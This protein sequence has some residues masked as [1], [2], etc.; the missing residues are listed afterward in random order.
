MENQRAFSTRKE[1]GERE[2]KH[3]HQ[4]VH[5][6]V[7]VPSSM[8][9]GVS[10]AISSLVCCSGFSSVVCRARAARSGHRERWTLW[11]LDPWNLVWWSNGCEMQMVWRN[12]AAAFIQC[13]GYMIVVKWTRVC[14]YTRIWKKDLRS[15]R[16]PKIKSARNQLRA[17][18]N[19]LIW[20][21]H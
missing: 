13:I 7:I 18:R 6:L 15:S 3:R 20:M 14:V 4:V 16:A 12:M 21:Q 5:D 11:T 19:Q 8:G 10:L 17:D 1:A 9:S 2:R